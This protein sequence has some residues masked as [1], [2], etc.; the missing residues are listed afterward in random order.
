MCLAL[1]WWS[2]ENIMKFN[3]FLILELKD[4]SVFIIWMFYLSQ[5]C[6]SFVFNLDRCEIIFRVMLDAPQTPRISILQPI[7]SVDQT[8]FEWVWCQAEGSLKLRKPED[9]PTNAWISR[10]TGI[11]REI[12]AF[13]GKSLRLSSHIWIHPAHIR[14]FLWIMTIRDMIHPVR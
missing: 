12:W 9:F 14:T 1:S 13:V 5:T 2:Q 8:Y 3:L 4:A 10:Q 7:I 6:E 11:C